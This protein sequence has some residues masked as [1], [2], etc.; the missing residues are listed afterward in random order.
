MGL[1]NLKHHKLLLFVFVALL[2]TLV[3]IRLG[4]LFSGEQPGALDFS[5][6]KEGMPV[7]NL[8]ER[9]GKPDSVIGAGSSD[10][11]EKLETWMYL[12]DLS[13]KANLKRV[14]AGVRVDIKG[15]RVFRVSPILSSTNWHR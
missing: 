15:D 8:L 11:G 13:Q 6:I 7:Q 5:E 9:F 3:L 2:F 14:Y 10:E 1:R 4:S 12:V